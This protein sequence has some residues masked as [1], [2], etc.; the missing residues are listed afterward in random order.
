M[1]ILQQRGYAERELLPV[2]G[3]LDRP[4]LA[5]LTTSAGRLF[6]GIAA[7]LLPL[8]QTSGG[9]SLFEGQIAM[10]LEAAACRAV[11]DCDEETLQRQAYPFPLAPSEPSELDWRPLVAAIVADMRAGIDSCVI[12]QRFHAALAR[13]ILSVADEHRDL[14]VVLGGGVFQ[15]RLL[16][17]ELARLFAERRQPLGL[18]GKIP[19]N[20][21]GLAAGQLA[22]ALARLVA[23]DH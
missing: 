16:V 6:D 19:P 8:E 1:R 23:G 2:L 14:P 13:G 12:A 21:G 9:R 15:N 11:A 3:V 10:F 22:V 20:D 7:L 17:E 4:H 18:P 5:P